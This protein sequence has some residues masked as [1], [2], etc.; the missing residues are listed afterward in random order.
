MRL[1]HKEIERR[2]NAGLG[3]DETLEFK[4]HLFESKK[5]ILN[6]ILKGVVGLVNARGGNMVVGVE[7]K[8]QKWMICGLSQDEEYVKNWL[9]QLVYEYVEPDGLPF[10]VYPI[11]STARSVECIGIEVDRSE[12]R[13]FAIRHSGRSSRKGSSYYFPLRVGA[14]TRL[15]DFDSFLRSIVSNWAMGLTAISKTSPFSDYS[16]SEKS[17]FDLGKFNM[18]IKEFGNTKI[19]SDPE[20]ASI[21]RTELEDSLP[22]LPN[23][24]L[25]PWN[26]SLRNAT[27]RLI[28]LLVKEFKANE[29]SQK[30]K[31]LKIVLH[32]ACRADKKTLKRIEDCFL[33]IL[34]KRY[35]DSKEE[36]T[37]ELIKLLQIL[38]NN[39]AK[40]IKSMIE[41]AVEKWSKTEFDGLYND[42]DLDAYL[43]KNRKRLAKLRGFIL[44]SLSTAGKTQDNDKVDRLKKLYARIRSR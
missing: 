3:E 17:E 19:I 16:F 36:K 24:D 15:L 1:T 41:E 2:L 31:I 43:G 26:S 4:P 28:D 38:H 35:H 42:I 25:E 23:N 7:Q 22:D 5:G 11:D 6:P 37:S 44:K 30:R 18:R 21:V 10:R 13:Y 8:Q 39:K 14:S 12:A 29:K 33:D 40:Y 9:S 27:L 32:I 34:E 20:T